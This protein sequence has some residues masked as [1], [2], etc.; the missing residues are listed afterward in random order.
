MVCRRRRRTA[1]RSLEGI[2]IE[3]SREE[4]EEEEVEEDLSTS[5]AAG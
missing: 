5:G 1:P 2:E 3:I 4:E